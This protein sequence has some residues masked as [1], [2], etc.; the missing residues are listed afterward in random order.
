MKRFLLFLVIA[1]ASISIG[2][3]IYYFS[4]DNEVILIRSSYLT[5]EDGD[6]IATDGLVDFKHRDEHTQLTFKAQNADGG[7]S[8]LSY[9]ENEGFFTAESGKGGETKII[10]STTNRNYPELVINVLVCDGSEE[11]PYIITNAEALSQIGKADSKYTTDKNYKLGAD[12]S[13]KDEE[14]WAPISSF[15]GVFDGNFYTISNVKI[16]DVSASA[17][18]SDVGFISTLEQGAVVKNVTFKNLSIDVAG[19]TFVGAVAGRNKGTIM[20]TEVEGLIVSSKNDNGY[21]GGIVGENLYSTTEQGETKTAKVD[22][23]GFEGNITLKSVDTTSSSSDTQI[24][25]GIVGYNYA[26]VVSESYFRAIGDNKLSLGT[27]YFGGIVGLNAGYGDYTSN[28]YDCYCYLANGIDETTS[29]YNKVGGLVYKNES[30]TSSNII[31]GNYYYCGAYD[32]SGVSKLTN[33]NVCVN[34]TNEKD[35]IEGNCNKSLTNSDFVTQN[36]FISYIKLNEWNRYWAFDSVWGMGTTYPTLNVRSA[37]GSTYII[38]FSEIK[39]ANKIVT[40][41][42]LYTTLKQ[43]NNGSFELVGDKNK[44]IDFS[45]L[46]WAWGDSTH[47]LFDFNGTLTSDG[48]V[49]KNLK[50]VNTTPANDTTVSNVGLF[51]TLGL[52]ARVVGLKFENVTITY[53]QD[54]TSTRQA[55]NVGVLA[56]VSDGATIANVEI[57]GVNVDLN[58]TCFGGIVGKTNERA[59]KYFSNVTVKNVDATS[60]VFNYAGGFV[61]SNRTK[62]LVNRIGEEFAYN[63]LINI[64]LNANVVGGAFGVNYGEVSY[65][66]ASLIEF[67]MNDTSSTIFTKKFAY[68][69]GIAGSN[70]GK[71]SN[72]YVNFKAE[73]VSLNNFYVYAGGIVGCNEKSTNTSLTLGYVSDV[74]IKVTGSNKVYVGGLAG[75]NGGMISKSF[76][77]KGSLDCSVENYNGMINKLTDVP[78]VGG[79]V[80]F[81]S[82]TENNYSISECVSYITSVKGA[83]AGGLTGSANGKIEKCHSGNQ[84]NVVDIIGYV[85]GGLSGIV[86][87][88]IKDCYTICS[89]T[90]QY[91][92]NKYENISSI[93]NLKVSTVAGFTSVLTTSSAQI[94]GCYAVVTFKEGGVRLSTC[95]DI[96]SQYNQGKIVGGLYTTEGTVG[97]NSFGKI[98]SNS[99]LTGFGTNGYQTFFSNIGSEDTNVWD[100]SKGGYPQLYGVDSSLPKGKTT[101]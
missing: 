73:T 101:E 17:S 47:E 54:D 91:T 27:G 4:T 45:G 93:I 68:L 76:V 31:L 28:I 34:P 19:R 21:V 55:T 38:D 58:G 6:T 82:K 52:N 95:A 7:V 90:G 50:I 20:T 40:A 70:F 23:C 46:S 62:I 60:G 8:L 48:C 53:K 100:I 97:T 12:I 71:I 9:N 15:S 18:T 22:R 75:T 99:D 72:V 79:L 35:E 29:S 69:G 67:V 37:M 51:K 77:A 32:E 43:N 88:E 89:L 11:Y 56:G 74:Q 10:V 84:S 14:T 81:D 13:F 24:A 78:I 44:I 16:T 49:I 66:D 61:G 87:G 5:I 92:D 33:G 86:S 65:V 83:F 64:K 30:A 25:G 98:I 96:S 57:D 36:K 41:E 42:E 85:A 80:G 26:S 94:Q 3:T 1:I 63:K 59:D 39:G 2:L